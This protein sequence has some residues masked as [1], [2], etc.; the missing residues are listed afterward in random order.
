MSSYLRA[1]C[2]NT[3]QSGEINRELRLFLEMDSVKALLKK[4]DKYKCVDD[5]GTFLS[6][7]IFWWGLT[8]WNTGPGLGL[9]KLVIDFVDDGLEM[10]H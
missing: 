4:Y 9:R 7:E 2:N 1:D 5:N 6:H 3:L 8:D 10:N